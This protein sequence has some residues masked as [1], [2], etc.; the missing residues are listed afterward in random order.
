MYNTTPQSQS[1][2]PVKPA[3][4]CFFLSTVVSLLS[5]N[6]PPAER[7]GFLT[8]LGH[9]TISIESVTRQGNTLSSDEVDRFP[10]VQVRRTVVNLNDNGSIR[11]LEM[12]IHTPSEPPGQRDRKVVADAANNKVH[13]SKTDSTGTVNRDFPTGGS[14]VVAHVQQMYSLY[15]LFWRGVE[16]DIGI[17]ACG[18]QSCAD[19]AVLY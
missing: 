15:E 13:L 6:T 14:I 10:R 12:S 9:D 2:S 16:A 5:C 3:V 4:I 19:A 11:H 8:M 18:R 1:F 7:H 17:K